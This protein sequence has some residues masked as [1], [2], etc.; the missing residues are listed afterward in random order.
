MF[1]SL[2]RKEPVT[3][4][5]PTVVTEMSIN[6]TSY[7]N[8]SDAILLKSVMG[9]VQE[10]VWYVE[11]PDLQNDSPAFFSPVARRLLG[12]PSGQG[13]GLASLTQMIHPDY[14]DVSRSGSPITL[15]EPFRFM[16]PIL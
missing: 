9:L 11:A 5:V 7:V 14:R 10:G 15:S 13:T 16:M 4:R 3:E 8:S 2:F 6:E 12:L 1:R